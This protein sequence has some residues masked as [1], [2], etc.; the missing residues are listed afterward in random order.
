MIQP[1]IA[2][3]QRWAK[4][5]KY[6]TNQFL[7]ENE[8]E[9]KNYPKN[10]RCIFIGTAVENGALTKGYKQYLRRTTGHYKF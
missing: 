3:Y 9:I 2:D 1:T 8:E 5:R 10:D 7:K 4:E 6:L